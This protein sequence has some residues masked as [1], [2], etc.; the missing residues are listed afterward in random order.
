MISIQNS[1]TVA[2]LIVLVIMM[3][4]ESHFPFFTK[5][6]FQQTKPFRIWNKNNKKTTKK[7]RQISKA[8]AQNVISIL[9]TNKFQA[10]FYSTNLFE[11]KWIDNKH[12]AKILV[13][14]PSQYNFQ[15]KKK[16]IFRDEMKDE[17][18]QLKSPATNS[19]NQLTILVDLI[20]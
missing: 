13:K 16:Y 3:S 15:S 8:F 6:K 2:A 7:Y 11:P 17:N 9:W 14:W 4:N 10:L 20:A 19:P 1:V 12:S 18:Y 5:C